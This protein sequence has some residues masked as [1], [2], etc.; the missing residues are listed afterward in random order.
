MKS[1][2]LQT[3][4]S[5]WFEL[6]QILDDEHG[7]H[8]PEPGESD[9]SRKRYEKE[10]KSIMLLRAAKEEYEERQRRFKHFDIELFGEPSWDILLDLYIAD[11]AGKALPVTTVCVGARVPSS[12]ALRWINVLEAR[13]HIAR[14]HSEDDKRVNLLRLSAEA[15]ASLDTYFSGR[16]AR[17]SQC[18]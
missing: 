4:E 18:Q 2:K 13:G 12:T 6:G 16:I 11:I 1:D 15:R 8:R 3:I 17:R 10:P 14:S 5:L 9:R 7:R